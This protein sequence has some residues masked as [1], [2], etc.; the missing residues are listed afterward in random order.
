M[1]PFT[2]DWYKEQCKELRIFPEKSRGQHFLIDT[3]IAEKMVEHAKLTSKDTVIEIGPGLGPLTF[4]LTKTNATILT[5]EIEK[6]MAQT[7]IIENLI[8]EHKI[9]FVNTDALHIDT[10]ILPKN[11]SV[12]SNLPY[13]ISSKAII[14]FLTAPHPPKQMILMLQ[15][16][17][18]EKI[19]APVGKLSRLAVL[20]QS[21][22]KAEKIINVP[23]SA[24]WPQPKVHSAV[25][26]ISHI[27]IPEYLKV[28]EKI[29]QLAFSAPR[30]KIKNTLATYVEKIEENA[31]LNIDAN[32]RP[33]DITIA[34]WQKIA[35][36]LH[37]CQ[38]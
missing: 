33:Q 3:T 18:V 15:K 22:G 23:R 28:L 26:K 8:S 25:I 6:K 32:Q 38:S 27:H 34:Q 29:T 36:M 16:E 37:A 31:K 5:Y 11:Y 21:V 20:V 9:S 19:I 1:T 14:H 7:P 2:T 24:F 35:Q 10:K 12:I 4:Q 13:S 30:K 17:V